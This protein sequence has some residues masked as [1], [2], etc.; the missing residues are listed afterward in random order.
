MLAVA[1]LLASQLTR[2]EGWA[3]IDAAGAELVPRENEADR[4]AAGYRQLTSELSVVE[5][6]ERPYDKTRLLLL[7]QE[8]TTM[9]AVIDGDTI[10]F[11]APFDSGV[12]FLERF[13]LSGGMPTLVSVH[14][15]RLAECLVAL[16]VDAA[17]AE[18][19]QANDTPTQ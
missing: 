10:T 3:I 15:A 12:S 6:G 9:A 8:R 19:L 4:L 11:A 16:G 13:D 1:R 5:A 14:R 2:E 7:G 17:E 18:R